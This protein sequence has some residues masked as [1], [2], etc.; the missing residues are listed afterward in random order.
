AR[1]FQAL[2]DKVHRRDFLWRA[3]T[4]VAANGGAPGVD[5][6]SIAQIEEQGVE[7]VLGLL[8]VLAAELRAGA[9]RPLPVRR[10]SIPKSLG[11]GRD[12]G[13]P[14]VRDRIV[15]AAAKLVLEPIYEADFLDCSYGFRPKRSAHQALEAIRAGANRGRV[16]VVDADIASFFDSIRPQVLASALEERIS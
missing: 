3:W 1:R 16:W 14:A 8:D 11:G 10:V 6:V 15:Q 7:G 5:G 12:L 2:F 9:Y 13:V 4:Q